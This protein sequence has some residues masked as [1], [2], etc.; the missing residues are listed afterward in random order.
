MSAHVR[1]KVR[2][3]I[4]GVWPGNIRQ[5]GIS[6]GAELRRS[7]RYVFMLRD[8]SMSVTSSSSSAMCFAPTFYQ[9]QQRRH[10][11]VGGTA[12]IS[13]IAPIQ[14]KVRQAPVDLPGDLQARHGRV[15]E[16]AQ[17]GKA[18]VVVMQRA[19]ELSVRQ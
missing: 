10:K 12:A 19:A 6:G 3:E 16:A 9:P 17:D 15:G 14:A 8:G 2:L 1:P 18:R 11:A 13:T 7:C 5:K 4:T